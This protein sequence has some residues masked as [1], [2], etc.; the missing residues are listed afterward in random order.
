MTETEIEEAKSKSQ[1]KRELHALRELGRELVDVP[2]RVLAGFPLDDELRQAVLQAKRFKREA[3][4]RQ[5]RYIASLMRRADEHAIRGA[6]SLLKQPHKTEVDMLH[7]IEKWRDA[8]L[9]GDEETLTELCQRF[10]E[11]DRQHI[12]QLLRNAIKERKQNKPPKS[13][14]HYFAIYLNLRSEKNE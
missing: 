11:L 10:P 8:L 5:I 1:I 6:L 12:R 4:R 9:Q 13:S 3:L 2:E 7:R 14:G